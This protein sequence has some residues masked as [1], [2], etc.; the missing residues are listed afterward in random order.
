MITTK[1]EFEEIL[2]YERKLIGFDHFS[3]YFIKLL[4]GSEKAEIWKVQKCL[5]YTEYYM[6]CNKRIRFYISKIR[7][8]H[9]QNKSGIHI[10]L[11]TCE[12]GLKIMHLGPVLINGHAHIGENC[13]IHINTVIAAS[14]TSEQAPI[15]G[16]NVVIG[17][18]AILIG[19]IFIGDGTAV[20]A[21][22]LVNKSFSEGNIAIAGVPAHKISNNGKSSWK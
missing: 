11:N 19:N 22:A 7:L 17:V 9:L 3:D 10:G 2:K 20:G 13:S 16:N 1:K 21:N 4:A 15:I 8:N 5:R 18:G 6:N 14:G 12:K